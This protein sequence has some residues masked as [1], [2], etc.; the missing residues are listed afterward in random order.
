MMKKVA[1]IP[2]ILALAE[3]MLIY[4]QKCLDSARYGLEL[5]LTAVL[6]SLLPFMAASFLLLNTG[7]VRLIA[8][9]FT[10]LTGGCST[11]PAR[12][13]MCWRR[14]RSPDIRWARVSP[15]SYT[16][17]ARYPNRTPSASCGSPASP[18]R[19]F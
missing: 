10:P 12:R 9:L 4:P 17:G 13:P 8:A 16:H 19:C 15:P 6:P 5:W 11:R 18:A 14:L 7:V 3:M 2:I 1:I